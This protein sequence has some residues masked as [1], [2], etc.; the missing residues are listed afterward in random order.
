MDVVD[1]FCGCGGF[2]QGA[3]DAGCD[4]VLA[5]DNWDVAL[6][7]HK[8]NHA[9][10]RHINMTI[11][12]NKR[13]LEIILIEEISRS[14]SKGK[15]IHIHASPPC[16]NIS[17]ANPYRNISHGVTMVEW[18]VFLFENVRP[19]SW[20]IENVYTPKFIPLIDLHGG[21]VVNM[22]EIGLPQSRKRVFIGNVDISSYI[23]GKRV[24]IGNVLRKS[25]R[26]DWDMYVCK[27]VNKNTMYDKKG[28]K[29]GVPPPPMY[30][31]RELSEPSYTITSRR[32][33]LIHIKTFRREKLTISESAQVQ[34]FPDNYIWAKGVTDNSKMIGNAVPP[35]VSKLVMLNIVKKFKIG[36]KNL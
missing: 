11:D 23:S 25:S 1:I 22:Q 20:S 27:N 12:P 24:G 2:S 28:L 21:S 14:R 16:Q 10:T 34:S 5:I 8:K 32:P 6:Q 19:D 31:T 4:V 33:E 26:L 30:L 35:L 29:T 36:E 7:I 13:D 15:K 9:S 17:R 3:Y 18:V